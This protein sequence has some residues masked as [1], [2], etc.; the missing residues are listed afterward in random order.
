MSKKIHLM[1]EKDISIVNENIDTLM[2]KARNKEIQIIEPTLTEFKKI[3]QVILDFIKKE[4]RII[5]GGYAWNNLIKK[6]N[7]S[8]V[9][10]KETDY[11]DIEFYSNKPIEDMKNICDILY[12]KGYNFIQGK[13]AQHDDTYTI[14][15][16]FIGFCDISYMPSN[17]FYSVMTENVDGY[18]MIHP[19]FIF[20]DILRQF[21]DPMTSF[22]RLD[23]GVKRGKIMMKHYPIDFVD[24]N[25]IDINDINLS[26]LSKLSTSLS[27][28]IINEILPLICKMKDILFIGL[29][30]FDAYINPNIDIL[31]QQVIYQ[32]QPIELI[33]TNVSKDVETIYNLIVKYYIDINKSE[34][35]NDNILFEQYFPFFQFTDKKVIFKHNGETFLTIYG[36]NEKCIPYNEI[37]LQLKQKN[38]K[39]K[40][41]TFNLCFMYNLINFHQAYINKNIILT[42]LYDYLMAQMLEKRNIFLDD[43]NK[44]V[45]DETLFEDFKVNCIGTPISPMRKFMLSRKDRKLLPRSAIYPYDPEERK[46]DYPT[47]IYFFNNYSGNIINNPKEFIYNNKKISDTI[48]Q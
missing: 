39:I 44:T 38:Y 3:R 14:F 19:K 18:K 43:N 30:P 4:K 7:Q 28:E 5:Y 1:R 11:T 25:D 21:N 12:A 32:K 13:S 46:D 10:Y 33:N 22:W 42:K 40:I 36:N 20:V 45:L 27:S 16:N 34:Q 15:V 31:K 9:F 48:D 6:K 26:K 17:I 29:I 35:F 24:I 2:D 23:K 8:D 47:D 41:G 37:T